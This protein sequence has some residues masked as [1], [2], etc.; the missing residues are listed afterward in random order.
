MR[1][2]L[3][4]FDGCP[5]HHQ[6]LNNLQLALGE[7]GLDFEIEM[8]MIES[9]EEAA[10]KRFLGSPTIRINDQ[11]LEHGDT[12]C[13]VYSMNC[14]RYKHGSE[15]LGFPPTDLIRLNIVAALKA[16]NNVE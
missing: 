13:Q 3:Q 5:N 15:I 9:P 16:E 6:A 14:R 7:L 4:Y 12:D 1:I 2:E 10:T 8:V 11:D